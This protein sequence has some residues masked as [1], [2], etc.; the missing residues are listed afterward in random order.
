M[1]TIAR[2]KLAEARY[3]EA[4]SDR[5]LITFAPFDYRPESDSFWGHA[6]AE[7]LGYSAIGISSLS[8]RDWFPRVGIMPLI[9]E[10]RE[11]SRRYSTV[12]VYGGSMGGYGALKYGS[13]L[14]AGH[15]VAFAPQY[16]LD[17]RT[18]PETIYSRFYSPE[19]HKGMEIGAGDAPENS[20]ILYDP[21]H[22]TDAMRVRCIASVTPGL[23]L[24][25]LPYTGHRCIQVAAGTDRIA[26]I[27]D[28]AINRRI[29]EL[30]TLGRSLRVRS[31]L[32]YSTLA[33]AAIP[34]SIA[35]AERILESCPVRIPPKLQA[36]M[37]YEIAEHYL[38]NG[39][40]SL[41]RQASEEAVKLQ[42]DG[43]KFLRQLAKIYVKLELWGPAVESLQA[44]LAA[45]KNDIPSMITLAHIFHKLGDRERS[46]EFLVKAG[47]IDPAHPRYISGSASLHA[48]WVR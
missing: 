22:K 45:A 36:D 37:K 24:I 26:A 39:N 31:P 23:S 30:A 44:V 11:I 41:A 14:G 29:T 42:P 20:V 46:E 17:P 21:R 48:A 32:R 6:I 38:V 19:L 34:R 40:N 12:V 4:S 9:P 16:T 2:S 7:K 25:P 10:V 27:L 3:A 47:T 15:A 13:A 35:L 33:T 28:L 8:G 1:Q 5:L 43:P 18:E